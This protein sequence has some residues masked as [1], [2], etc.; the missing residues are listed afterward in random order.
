VRKIALVMAM[1]AEAAPIIAA[2]GAGVAERPGW[3]DRLPTRLYQQR[4]H[5]G[6]DVMIAVSGTDPS[7]GV[8]CIG[9]Q[10]AVLAAHAAI[11]VHRPD[12]V[13]SVG[14]AGG[15]VRADARIGDV[16]VAWDRFVHHDRRIG[17]PGFEAFGLGNHPAADIREVALASGCR[18]GVVTTGESLDESD[19]DRLRI[20]ESG[21][22]VK[23]ME[24]AAVA[25]MAGIH[26]TPV[27]AVKAITDLIDSPV[28]NETQF[29]D[30]LD[31][32]VEELR[33]TLIDLLPRLASVD[34]SRRDRS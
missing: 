23:D 34:L 11:T 17:I 25:W 20:L 6:I 12:L 31:H 2:L 16:F 1:E 28:A 9:G 14:T 10:A 21:A 22:Q 19:V 29:L 8:D 4:D 24:A 30:N 18:L 3:V 27:S 32:A 7:T 15:W 5:H 13:L 26:D 33:A